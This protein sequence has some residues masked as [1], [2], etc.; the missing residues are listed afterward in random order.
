MEELR[1]LVI[2]LT[3]KKMCW[4]TSSI[5]KEKSSLIYLNLIQITRNTHR[6]ITVASA[7]WSTSRINFIASKT[8][9]IVK[10][11]RMFW[12]SRDNW[13]EAWE[14][15]AICAISIGLLIGIITVIARL[16]SPYRIKRS[17]SHRPK[18]WVVTWLIEYR[19]L[20]VSISLE[21]IIFMQVLV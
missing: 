12:I 11:Y 8:L 9:R 19:R 2:S 7:V 15:L 1:L 17:C 20:Q 13:I 18:T 10:P 5:T 3:I 21:L 4:N 6:E 16:G 14:L